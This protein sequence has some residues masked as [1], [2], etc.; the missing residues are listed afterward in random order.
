MQAVLIVAVVI[1]YALTSG[2]SI[3]ESQG[4][5]AAF[6]VDFDLYLLS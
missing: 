6:G 5:I 4:C 3:A 2:M 1:P